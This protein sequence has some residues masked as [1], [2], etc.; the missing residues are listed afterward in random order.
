MYWSKG[1]ILQ[2]R[3][4]ALKSRFIFF[5][6]KQNIYEQTSLLFCLL[7]KANKNNMQYSINHRAIDF[8]MPLPWKH[9]VFFIFAL[10]VFTLHEIFSLIYRHGFFSPES[11]L[12]Y[13]SFQNF[14]WEVMTLIKRAC[15]LT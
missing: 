10:L 2:S 8:S 9:V 1:E 3:A 12:T 5:I 13:T 4:N 15:L 14:V 7:I 11:T 6:K